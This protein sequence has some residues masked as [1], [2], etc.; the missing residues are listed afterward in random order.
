M[1]HRNLLRPSIALFALLAGCATGNDRQTAPI[2]VDELM[3]RVERVHIE[4]ERAR[5][6]ISDA[7]DRLNVLAAGRFDED[8]AA[9]MYARFVQSIDVADE[10]AK[11][12]QEAVGPMLESAEPVFENWKADIA[13]IQ[14]ER[15]RQRGE[16]RFQIAKE[17]YDAIAKVAV[18]AREQLMAF[19][20]A[21]RDHA[22]FLGHDL[23]ASAIDDIQEEVKAVAQTAL[24]LDRNLE[25]TMSSTRAYAEQSS[26]PVAAPSR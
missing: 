4:A 5:D 17:R 23:N 16:V 15:L 21:L 6:S 14:S 12:F 19:V 24:E 8:P 7:F 22:L 10:Q 13:M 20:A 18:P 9:V 26:L 25:T 11:R 2:K 3:T 1:Q